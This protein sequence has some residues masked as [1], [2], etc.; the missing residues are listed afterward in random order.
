MECY[1]WGMVDGDRA[2]IL[3]DRAERQPKGTLYRSAALDA[4]RERHLS[5]RDHLVLY[6]DDC[7]DGFGAAWAAWRR[8]GEKAGYAPVMHGNPPPAVAGRHVH[9]LDFSYPR[10]TLLKMAHEAASLEVVDHHKTAQEN[11]KGLDFCI[12][13][14]DKCGAVL[15][16]ERFH[17][18]TPVP[19]LLL[20]VQDKDLWQWRLPESR[21]ITCALRG[22]PFEFARW[23]EWADDWPKWREVLLK[24]GV[25]ILRYQE[26]VIRLAVETATEIDMA[27]H[28]VRVANSPILQSEI[29]GALAEGRPFGV[30]WYQVGERRY[31]SLR[32]RDGG[33]DVSEVARRF[34][35]GGHARASGFSI[36]VG[37]REPDL[38]GA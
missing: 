37:E 8:L 19:E 18:E 17:P 16:W 35:G 20:H 24:E 15:S 27:G 33:I 23:S 13:D 25:A 26:E 11:L 6:H 1:E 29:A 38:S 12:F 7:I 10:D 9:I 14:M 3:D 31:Y 22:H 36:D 28:R 30:A 4:A 32:S 34:G 2:R 21:E 5:E